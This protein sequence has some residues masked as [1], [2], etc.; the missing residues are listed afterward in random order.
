MA[1]SAYCRFKSNFYLFIAFF[2]HFKYALQIQCFLSSLCDIRK[3]CC[4]SVSGFCP[5]CKRSSIYL[6][7]NSVCIK[8]FCHYTKYHFQ[9]SNTYRIQINILPLSLKL[10]IY[11]W[12]NEKKRSWEV[13]NISNGHT[14]KVSKELKVILFHLWRVNPKTTRGFINIPLEDF[15]FT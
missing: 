13:W 14:R 6:L 9:R 4:F 12:S 10:K 11:C 3:A 5:S 15:H 2:T 8:E 7:P 1:S